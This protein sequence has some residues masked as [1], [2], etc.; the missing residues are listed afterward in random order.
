MLAED[1]M[2]NIQLV[3]TR[4]KICAEY[5]STSVDESEGGWSLDPNRDVS[6]HAKLCGV[7]SISGPAT[8]SHH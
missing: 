5:S 4:S 6:R 7:V 3:D 1:M 2:V 8:T